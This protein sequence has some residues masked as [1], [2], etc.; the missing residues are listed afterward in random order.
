[1]GLGWGCAVMALGV[2]AAYPAASELALLAGAAGFTAGS[3]T[4]KTRT[5][6]NALL[7]ADGIHDSLYRAAGRSLTSP[8]RAAAAEAAVVSVPAMRDGRDQ[9]LSC[10]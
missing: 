2:V 8:A 7:Y 5:D 9:T 10:A 6:L 3:R 4:A 1:V